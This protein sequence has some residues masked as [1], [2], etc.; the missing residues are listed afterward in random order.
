M[1]K[2]S[3]IKSITVFIAGVSAASMPA[4]ATADW[5][6]VGLG[7]LG[8]IEDIP[9][10][11]A[12]D[13][14]DYGQVTG[15]TFIGAKYHAFITGPNGVGMTDLGTL[16]GT[17]TY[18]M[19][20]NNSGQVAGSADNRH[21][22]ITGPNGV[23]MTDLGTLGGTTAEALGI[24]DSG[25]VVG[26]FQIPGYIN[27]A[28]ITGPNG[29][30]MTDLGTLGGAW[31][32]AQGINNSGQVV[33]VYQKPGS[34]FH[35][36]ITGPNG[37]GMTDLGIG[38]IFS[39]ALGINDSGQVVGY[40]RLPDDFKYHAFVTGPN[41]VGIT[42]L[43]TLGGTTA[44]ALGINDSGQVVG[45]SGNGHAFLYSNG[46]ITELSWLP[47]V[48][49]SGW[50]DLIPRAINNNGQIVGWGTHGGHNE[51]FLLSFSPDTVFPFIT[52]PPPLVPEPE[53]YA[54]L[55]AGLGLLG[56]MTRRRKV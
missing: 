27:H 51:A 14:N 22:F 55:L 7:T 56:F 45:Y 2:L 33:G 38:G 32:V 3:K 1:N 5:S 18:G 8:G 48:V 21:A 46:G 40:F 9:F 35:A 15:V 28:F 42:D 37:V 6:F 44:E 30:G 23:G 4:I 47:I 52:T 50:T 17:S 39:E 41:G 43:G 24:N 26:L 11:A 53:T 16:D 54:M 10:S 25:Q 13:I 12:F 19:G 49:A 20:I 36:F 34:N 29:V 31:S